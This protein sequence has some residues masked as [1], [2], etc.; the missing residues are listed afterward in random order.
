MQLF[1][2]LLNITEQNKG[3]IEQQLYKKISHYAV[4]ASGLGNPNERPVRSDIIFPD[5]NRNKTC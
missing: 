3:N 4:L 5:I 2:L 1:P